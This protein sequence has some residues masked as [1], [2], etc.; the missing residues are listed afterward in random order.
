MYV[1]YICMFVYIFQENEVGKN[2]FTR[3]N[4]GL[5]PSQMESGEEDIGVQLNIKKA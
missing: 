3:F 2:L 5:G 1:W 4:N